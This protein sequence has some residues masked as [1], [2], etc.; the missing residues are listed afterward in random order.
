MSRVA[1]SLLS[2]C[3]LAAPGIAL[4][5]PPPHAGHGDDHYQDRGRDNDHDHDHDHDRKGPPPGQAKKHWKK[6]ETLPRDHRGDYV[7]DYRKHGLH[8]PPPGHQWRRVND[9][10]VLI[11]VATGVIASVI[12]GNH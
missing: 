12:L 5:A 6:G 1:A 9:E 2:L 11:A 10:Y 3:L 8:S 4:A 7:Q